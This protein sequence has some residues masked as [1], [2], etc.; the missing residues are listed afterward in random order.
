MNYIFTSE[1]L[2]FKLWEEHHLEP[3][4]E[5]NSDEETMRFFVETMDS[6]KSRKKMLQMNKMFKEH[7]Y[8]YFAVELKETGEF[9]GTIGLGY[10]E[11]EAVFTPCTDIGWRIRR[12]FWN[13][14]YSTE[15]AKA[16]LKYGKSLG[17]KEVVSMATVGNHPSIRVMEKIGMKYW[18]EF[19]HSE[20]NDSPHLNPMSLYRITL[21]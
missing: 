18:L 10:K 15:G 21:N 6:E 3:F 14:G 13:Q 16:C 4:T 17:L 7:N 5:M 20:L 8:C 1:R 11:F 2:G 19:N 9:L 12:K